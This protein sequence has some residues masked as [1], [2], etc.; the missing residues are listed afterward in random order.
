MN[1][2]KEDWILWG[3]WIQPALSGCF[4]THWYKAEVLKDIIPDI[5]FSPILFLD[6]YTFISSA[7]YQKWK[8][9]IEEVFRKKSFREFFENLEKHSLRIES[10][11]IEL[12]EK[13]DTI[14]VEE[15]V[16]ELFPFTP[17]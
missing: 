3:R 16:S 8:M 12:F 1:L 14:G 17:N 4:W 9:V 7:N 6:G 13:K 10:R 11:Y 15:Y 2:H 5:V